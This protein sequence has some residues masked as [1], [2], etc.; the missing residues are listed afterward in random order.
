MADDTSEVEIAPTAAVHSRRRSPRRARS[1]KPSY[2]EA[3]DND[4]GDEQDTVSSDA[5]GDKVGAENNKANQSTSR[6]SRPNKQLQ[7]VTADDASTKEKFPTESSSGTASNVGKKK[8]RKGGR[9]K[10]SRNDLP[11]ILPD[12]P[13]PRRKKPKPNRPSEWNSSSDDEADEN[14][15]EKLGTAARLTENGGYLHTRKSRARIGKGNK[16]KSPWN[17]GRHRSDAD[18]ERIRAGVLAKTREKLL[19]KLKAIGLTEEEYH[20]KN[21]K[22][23]YLREQ[24]RRTESRIRSNTQPTEKQLTRLEFLRQAIEDISREL[25]MDDGVVTAKSSDDDC[26]TEEGREKKTAEAGNSRESTNQKEAGVTRKL[27]KP[28]MEVNLQIVPDVVAS[29]Y[30]QTETTSVAPDD[31]GERQARR[32][33]E[34]LDK[35][36]SEVGK[37]AKKRT[38]RTK[39]GGSN[40]RIHE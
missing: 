8:Q 12:E 25:G 15:L 35:A 4:D 26:A 13:P 38:R 11:P 33:I 27:N 36:K 32:L 19:L 18:K 14:E 29:E 22:L 1:T 20:A 30:P 10:Q 40:K 17:K 16:G 34:S 28:K 23:R 24:R 6:P 3:S 37:R 5:A 21:K 2:V 31:E 9:P 39:T 7:A